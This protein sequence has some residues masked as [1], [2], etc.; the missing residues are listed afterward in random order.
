VLV[1]AVVEEMVVDNPEVLVVLAVAALV[2][3][4]EQEPLEQLIQ[5]VVVV[6]AKTQ[7]TVLLVVQE[8]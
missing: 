1:A 4:M 7:Q 6:E 3:Q 8:L 5:A 2:R